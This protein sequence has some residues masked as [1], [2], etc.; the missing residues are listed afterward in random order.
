MTTDPAAERFDQYKRKIER[1]RQEA[2]K[3]KAQANAIEAKTNAQLSRIERGLPE[4]DAC[5]D[6]WVERGETSIF[7]ARTADDPSRFDRW[8]CPKCGWHFDVPSR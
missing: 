5:P 1:E 6:C 4:S 2:E 7:V 8:G 3:L